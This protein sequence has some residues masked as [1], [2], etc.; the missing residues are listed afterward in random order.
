VRVG[1][2]YKAEDTQASS[3]RRPEV[4]PYEVARD[5]Q[6]LT[7]FQREAQPL[8]PE[9]SQICS[10]PLHRR[11]ELSRRFIAMEFLDGQTRKRLIEKPALLNCDILLVTPGPRDRDALDARQRT[12]KVSFICD[13][14]SSP[15]IFFVTK[16]GTREDS[17]LRTG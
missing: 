10:D 12:R 13:R 17:G 6:S 4:L 5:P 14:P 9:S 8:L 3:L 7:R 2:F 15:P 11:R 16:R 1:V